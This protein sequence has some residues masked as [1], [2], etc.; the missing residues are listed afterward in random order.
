MGNPY[1]DAWVWIYFQERVR[2]EPPHRVF[3]IDDNE[4]RV[5]TSQILNTCWM[6]SK[7]K[8]RKRY[9]EKIGINVE[10]HS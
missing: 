1:G 7:I 10:N 2:E 9:A 5:R 8:L 3:R 4:I 6:E